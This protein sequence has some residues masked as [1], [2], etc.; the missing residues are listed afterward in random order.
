MLVVVLALVV[1]VVVTQYCTEKNPTKPIM[2]RV[3]PYSLT[4]LIAWNALP[5]PDSEA[6]PYDERSGAMMVVCRSVSE[7]PVLEFEGLSTSSFAW[8]SVV[9]V[10][11]ALDET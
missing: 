2:T 1:V 4:C 8:V 6:N 10:S 3:C 9:D 7:V 11:P 5:G